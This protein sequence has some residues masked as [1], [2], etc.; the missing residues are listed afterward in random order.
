[1]PKGL[2]PPLPNCLPSDFRRRD[3]IKNGFEELERIVP[4]AGRL[5]GEKLSQAS[6]L[7]DA[8]NHIKRVT[9][10]SADLADQIQA[11]KSEMDQLNSQIE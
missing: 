10:E 11:V 1:M 2:V 5:D 4:H 9:R 3:N 8:G 7:F 6:V